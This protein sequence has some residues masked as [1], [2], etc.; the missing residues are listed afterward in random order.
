VKK[1][2]FPVV[3]SAL[4]VITSNAWS[5]SGMGGGMGGMGSG[6]GDLINGMMGGMRDRMTDQDRRR[7]DG[8][9]GADR[10]Q[11]ENRVYRQHYEATRDI[12]RAMDEKQKA[13]DGES[14]RDNPNQE[15]L[16]LL[17]EEL[18]E[19]QYK[20]N[21]EQQRFERYMHDYNLNAD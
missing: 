19:L 18:D 16:S 5:H 11:R 14:H 2:V 21:F 3:C 4:L 8:Y 20:L 6:L 9:Q 12:H 7:D 10:L 15:K 13:I 17:H 1:I